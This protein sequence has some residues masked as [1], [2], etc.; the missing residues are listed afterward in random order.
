MA[1][2]KYVTKAGSTVQLRGKN[3]KSTSI[4]LDW[5]EEGVCIEAHPT[6]NFDDK[7]PAIIA[8]CECH[9]SV[10]IPL[11]QE[12]ET[13]HVNIKDFATVPDDHELQVR[14]RVRGKNLKKL[15]FI[16]DY[17]QITVTEVLDV[18]LSKYLPESYV[19]MY[20]EKL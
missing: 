17:K 13:K 14:F 7:E 12:V 1:G 18:V 8:D 9:G 10:D 15:A 19:D 16:A 6:F 5:I 4:Y 3:N 11:T 20:N 2:E